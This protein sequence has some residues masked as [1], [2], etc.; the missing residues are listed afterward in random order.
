MVMFIDQ[1]M[2]WCLMCIVVGDVV[3]IIVKGFIKML[4]GRS[5]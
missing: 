5:R 4:K 1:V 3:L 2:V